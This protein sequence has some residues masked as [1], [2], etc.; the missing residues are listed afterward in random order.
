MNTIMTIEEVA[1]FLKVSRRTVEDWATKG[2]LRGAE[3]D[4][5]WRFKRSDVEDFVSSKMIRQPEKNISELKL[6]VLLAKERIIIIDKCAKKDLFDQMINMLS[7][8]P[9]VKNAAELYD[10]VYEREELMS[11]GIGLNLGIPHVRIKS[12]KD[13]A[14]AFALVKSGVDD[15]EALDSEP[16]KLV[17]MIIAREDQ[18]ARHLRFLSQLSTVMKN[19]KFRKKLLDCASADEVYSLLCGGDC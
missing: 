2:E 12:V 5:A 14:V 17:F 8:T 9:I 16:V 4:G 6:D 11:T 1:Q 18:H 7:V 19:D 13:M 15:Y 10:A 3:L